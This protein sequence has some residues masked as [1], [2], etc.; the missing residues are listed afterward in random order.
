MMKH[1]SLS[2]TLILLVLVGPATTEAQET[3]QD[4]TMAAIEQALQLT[5]AGNI[6]QALSDLEALRQAGNND[7]PLLAALGALYVEARQPERALEIL[8]PMAEPEDANPAVLYNAGRAAFALGMLEEAAPYFRRSL[9]ASTVASPAARELGLLRIQEGHYFRAYLLLRQWI[10]TR[11]EDTQARLAA[12]LCAV[13]LERAPEAERLLSDLPQESPLVKLLWARILLLKD[14][15]WGA[16]AILKPLLGNA[17]AELDLD[18]R[19]VAAEARLRV[20][21]PAGAIELLAEYAEGD[22]FV[23]RLLSRAYEENGDRKAAVATLRPFAEAV[24]AAQGDDS[25]GLTAETGGAIAFDYGR[26]L[27]AEGAHEEAVEYLKMAT[28]MDEWNQERWNQLGQSLLTLGRLQAAEAAFAKGRELAAAEN[29]MLAGI[30]FGDDPDDPTARQLEKAM[31][32]AELSSPVEALATVQQETMLA[33]AEDPRPRYIEI[34]LLMLLGRMDEA[35][36]SA[37]E[38]L[39]QFPFSADAYYQVAIVE[40]ARE[41]LDSAEENLDRALQL[42][43]DHTAALNDLAVLKMQSGKTDEAKE[44]LERILALRPD[45]PVAAANLELL[46]QQEQP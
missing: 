20:G 4:T 40:M 12:A 17:P 18:S 22:P 42:A 39:E 25:T 33:A 1:F 38:L 44:L 29:Q 15:A 10:E 11:P 27:A 13:E 37:D 46:R 23:S 35:K 43:P 30:Q 21:E 45:D 8:R 6:G 16:L 9:D 34:R 41:K 32:Q 2:L 24:L 3:L 36:E 7:P 14:D 31:R 26:L 28:A 19:R 5:E